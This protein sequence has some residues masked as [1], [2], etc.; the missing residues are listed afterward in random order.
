MNPNEIRARVV[1]KLHRDGKY[2]PN[3][4]VSVQG[5]ASMAVGASDEGEAKDLL[6]DEM[7]DDDT[8]PI[9]WAV[10]GEAVALERDDGKITAYIERHGGRNMLP[11]DLRNQ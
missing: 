11:W 5:A 10:A 9:E 4:M 7:V 6:T 1:L 3:E 8:C 2:L